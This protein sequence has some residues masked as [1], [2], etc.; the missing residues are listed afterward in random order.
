MLSLV[1]KVLNKILPKYWLY[2]R[3]IKLLVKNEESYLHTSGWIRSLKE[4]KPVD[5]DGNELPWINYTLLAF[6]RERLKK[7][8]NLFEFGGG[9]STLFYA[10]LVQKV[11]TVEHEDLW[12]QH[13]NKNLPDNV[14]LIYMPKDIDGKYC[15][16]IHSTGKRYD[17]V[18]VDGR[19]RVNCIKQSIKALSNQGVILLDDSYRERYNTVFNF[20]K[21]NGFFALSFE[22][23]KPNKA[24]VTKTTIF[25]RRKNCLGL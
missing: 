10:R 16:V 18:I 5:L 20:A 1:K 24:R 9:Y 25:Y 13:I 22:G 12:Y 17:L 21:D 19:D 2:A 11:T 14:E 8:F 4:Q 7:D 3:V 15:R 23:L 6:L